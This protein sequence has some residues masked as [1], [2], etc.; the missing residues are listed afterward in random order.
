MQGNGDLAGIQQDL[1]SLVDN[2][3]L[4][5]EKRIDRLKKRVK[6]IGL[7][8][9]FVPDGICFGDTVQFKDRSQ[10]L[11]RGEIQIS[12]AKPGTCIGCQNLCGFEHPQDAQ[13][14]VEI[15][16][17]PMLQRLQEMAS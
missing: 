2:L 8:L 12:S 9:K 1:K 3:E 10:C 16:K 13:S 4:Q 7:I 17:S 11:T 6:E 15:S 14:I 5:G